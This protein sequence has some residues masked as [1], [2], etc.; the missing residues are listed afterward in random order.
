MGNQTLG[1]GKIMFSLLADDGI[2]PGGTCTGS[3][4]LPEMVMQIGEQLARLRLG[5]G[6]VK[7]ELTTRRGLERYC[8]RAGLRSRAAWAAAKRATGTRKGEHE[9]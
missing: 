5:H 8:G 2:T 4:W 9:T 6:F 7:K 1:R 3:D